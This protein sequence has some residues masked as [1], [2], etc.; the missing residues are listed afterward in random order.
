[1]AEMTLNE[2][3]ALA[4]EALQEA[5]ADAANAGAVARTIARAERD[6]SASHGLFRLPGYVGALKSGQ[7]NGAADPELTD[8]GPGVLRVDAKKGFAPLAQERVKAPLV[9]RARSQGIA[10]A[11][12]NNIHHFA[13][14]WPEVEMLAEEGLVGLA[15]TGA[16]PYVAPAGGR[17]PLFGTNP[18]AFAWPR[19]DGGSMAFDQASSMRARGDLMIAAR[20]G[21]AV[22]EGSGLDADGQPTTDPKAILEGGVQLAFG[23]YKGSAIAMMV[24]LLAGPLIGDRLSYEA[25]EELGPG[26]HLPIGGELIIAIDPARTSGGADWQA[27]GERLLQRI[28]GME[29][30]R[31]PGARRHENRKGGATRDVPEAVL[32]EIARVR[33]G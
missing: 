11:A 26:N 1:M 14:L 2:I 28:E 22:E 5:G 9:D 10:M 13:A 17:E 8:R 31:L 25:R 7:V 4:V 23:G 20:E 32:A 33:G 29:G 30:A 18:M 24:E 27:G 19:P 6:G 3:E 16:L 15:V 21:H 12:L